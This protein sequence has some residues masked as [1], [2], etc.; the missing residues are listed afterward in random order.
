MM[1]IILTIIVACYS[2]LTYQR[3]KVWRDEL[4]L[5]GDV[6][7]KSP[8]KARAYI[9]I[10]A[11]YVKQGNLA[12]ALSGYNKAIEM[13]PGYADIYYNRG[14]VYDKQGNFTMALSDYNKAIEI[15]PADA[16]IYNNRAATYYQLKEYDK[17]WDDVRKIKGLGHAASPKLIGLLNKVS[18]K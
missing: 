7:Q 3:N 10:G 18:G 9:S 6:L 14:I 16:D 11:A 4:T 15:N 13:N 2:V 17:A 1:L 5:W 8:H 12:Q